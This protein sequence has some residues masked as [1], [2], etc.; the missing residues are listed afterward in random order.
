GRVAALREVNEGLRRELATAQESTSS[1]ESREQQKQE[2]EKLRTE[3]SE[4]HKLRNEVTQL[5]AGAKEVERLR[6]E[7]QKL[8]GADRQLQDAPKAAGTTPAAGSQEGFYAKENW[9]F[10]GY[11]TPEAALQ[12]FV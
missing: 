11:A 6:A 9:T 10:S 1:N 3:V 2:L 12:S 5:R 8:R 7:N 4:V